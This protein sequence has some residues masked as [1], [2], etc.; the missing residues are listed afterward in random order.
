MAAKK[1]ASNWLAAVSRRDTAPREP[2][3]QADADDA[4]APTPAPTPVLPAASE[5]DPQ[6][7]VEQA[8][9]EPIEA[10]AAPDAGGAEPPVSAT[11][12]TPAETTAAVSEAADTTGKERPKANGKTTTRAPRAPRAAP[13]KAESS[14]LPMPPDSASSVTPTPV[15]DEPEPAAP[16]PGGRRK[17]A[18]KAVGYRLRVPAYELI[19]DV[20]NALWEAGEEPTKD[21]LV[22]AAILA[23]Y[24]LGGAGRPARLI[25]RAES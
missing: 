5:E 19:E 15:P 16:K 4:T 12:T 9:A 20:Y 23:H 1:P 22:S 17:V 10:V 11:E 24:G 6:A 18:R 21:D 3:D 8:P 2:L 7:P 25:D 14:T 13:V